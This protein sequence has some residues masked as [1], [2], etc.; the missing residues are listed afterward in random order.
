MAARKIPITERALLQRTNRV[1]NKKGERL[2]AKK[3]TGR[4]YTVH[5]A[6]GVVTRPDV[7]IEELGREIGTLRDWEELADKA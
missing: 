4:Y 2:Y 3:G 1:L 5:A 6:R 7:S